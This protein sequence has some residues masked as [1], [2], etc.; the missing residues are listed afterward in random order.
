MLHRLTKSTEPK[1][2]TVK[3]VCCLSDENWETTHCDSC[4][5]CQDICVSK[6]Y[7]RRLNIY[8]TTVD[9]EARK[10]CLC[11]GV[12]TSEIDNVY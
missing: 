10:D 8:G 9:P 11:H 6:H 3:I 7:H 12:L 4:S 2:Y 5:V 1:I